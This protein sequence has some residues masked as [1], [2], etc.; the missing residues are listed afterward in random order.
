MAT[1]G[2][3]LLAEDDRRMRK[4]YTDAFEASGY[5]IISVCDGDEALEMLHSLQP[6]V[7]LLD[8]MMPRLSG[9]ETC[10]R[11]RKMV[12]SE[13]PIIFLTA[14]NE[15]DTLQ[16]CIAAGG[17]DYLI[18]SESVATV[19]ERVG[20]WVQRP[21]GR[22]QLAKRREAMLADVTAEVVKEVSGEN[23]AVPLSSE[24][25]ES[26]REI[27]E[28]L[29]EA[30]VNAAEG[31]GQTV[32]EKLYLLGYTTGVVEHWARLRNAL[33]ERFFDYLGAALNE[34]GILESDEVSEMLSGF[35]DLSADTC[36]GI[37]R[38]HGLN[39]PAQRQNKG[40]DFAPIGLGQFQLLAAV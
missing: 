12:G 39:D 7:I 3:I 1:S 38:A 16:E 22:Y 32:E 8:I 5:S 19:I 34:T 13:V 10:M 37:A 17:D 11:A 33:E 40:K 30:R 36:F 27:S 25:D 20:Q 4:L 24:T 35:D 31:F 9:I 14:M 21:Q 6:Q 29:R 26:V 2:V 23:A 15:L 18:K 28:F